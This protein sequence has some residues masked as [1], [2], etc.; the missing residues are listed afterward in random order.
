[1]SALLHAV[2]VAIT[3]SVFALVAGALLATIQDWSEED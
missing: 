2:L 1:M 3:L